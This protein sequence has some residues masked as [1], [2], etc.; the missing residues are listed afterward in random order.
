MVGLSVVT[1]FNSGSA[2]YGNLAILHD[3]EARVRRLQRHQ[4]LCREQRIERLRSSV[5]GDTLTI[6]QARPQAPCPQAPITAQTS[7]DVN[8]IDTS[9]ERIN[10]M[11]SPIR[12]RLRSTAPLE[13][14]QTFSAGARPIA[15]EVA[16]DGELCFVPITLLHQSE[17]LHKDAISCQHNEYEFF[18]VTEYNKECAATAAAIS[19]LASAF[20]VSD[21]RALVNKLKGKNAILFMFKRTARAPGKLANP[22]KPH[23][24]SAMLCTLHRIARGAHC[25]STA[26]LPKHTA[27]LSVEYL[28]THSDMGRQ[29]FASTLIKCATDTLIHL[30]STLQYHRMYM[31]VQAMHSAT[32]FWTQHVVACPEATNLNGLL[33]AAC[34]THATYWDVVDMLSVVE[35]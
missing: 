23:V 12:T 4:R 14:L 2:Q 25:A 22:Y 20:G 13:F 5:D 30:L 32:S 8:V 1:S 34:K 15:P 35:W 10:L 7:K 18:T 29:S 17:C 11:K 27:V 21:N 3:H 24:A 16:G 26:P 9:N 6:A 19:L 28:K 33:K 31:L